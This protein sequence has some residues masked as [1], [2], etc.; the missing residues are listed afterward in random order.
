[1]AIFTIRPIHTDLSE[2]LDY[3]M[4][5]RK[6]TVRRIAGN[7]A[8]ARVETNRLISGVNCHVNQVKEEMFFVQKRFGKQVGGT[9]G[10]HGVLSFPYGEV[11]AEKCH[12]IGIRFAEE[13]WGKEYQV[14]VSTHTNTDH[15][16]SHFVVNS[17]SMW[18]GKKMRIDY[19]EYFRLCEGL[20]NLCL[21]EGLS[22]SDRIAK[23]HS[24]RKTWIERDGGPSRHNQIK[25]SVERILEFAQTYWEFEEFMKYE[26]YIMDEIWGE[27]G[28]EEF[29]IRT[30]C[31]KNMMP[32][33]QVGSEYH[34]YYLDSR[35]ERNCKENIGEAQREDYLRIL[36][37]EEK[38]L[39][40][41]FAEKRFNPE[42]FV[43]ENVIYEQYEQLA[44]IIGIGEDRKPKYGIL[45]SPE[46]KLAAWRR[47]WY[48]RQLE[49]VRIH[50]F[51]TIRDLESY[52]EKRKVEAGEKHGKEGAEARKEVRLLK[53]MI[54]HVPKIPEILSAERDTIYFRIGLYLELNKEERE[55]ARQQNEKTIGLER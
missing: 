26:G 24:K 43:A 49:L 27:Y 44:E 2:K 17:V 23:W 13:M 42:D 11:S 33:V 48:E 6:T 32:L 22:V 30:V 40:N 31:E 36:S 46:C 37:K 7:G 25:A 8:E 29:L 35:I 9:V 53:G 54:K 12:E 47:E 34:G 28:V 50:K 41:I 52:R 4:N 20:N 51:E 39:R 15:M 16:H 18:T 45:Y 38:H 14:L 1:M 19:Q 3:V 21:Q 10:Y 55:R 5:Q